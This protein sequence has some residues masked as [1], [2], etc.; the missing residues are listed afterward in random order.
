MLIALTAGPVLLVHCVAASLI[1]PRY[2]MSLHVNYCNV[3]DKR[4]IALLQPD[5]DSP[6]TLIKQA[7]FT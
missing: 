1:Q 7:L 2:N 5:R 3:C 6:R 4:D